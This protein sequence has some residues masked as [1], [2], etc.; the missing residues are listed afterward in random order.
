M[1]TV[2]RCWHWYLMRIARH[3]QGQDLRLDPKAQEEPVSDFEPKQPYIYQPIGTVGLT[4]AE[5][6]NPRIFSLGG[7]GT[8]AYRWAL[9]TRAEAELELA[10]ISEK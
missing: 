8:E 7:P 3:R 1:L 9:M 10:R 6:V 4:E 2:K 5:R